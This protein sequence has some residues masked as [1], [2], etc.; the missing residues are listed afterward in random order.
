MLRFLFLVFSL[1]VWI[2]AEAAVA[3]VLTPSLSLFHFSDG[4]KREYPASA[5]EH[6]SIK[7]K[8][9]YT[10][11][12]LGVCY[13]INGFCLGLKYLQGEI[14]SKISA[15]N[16]NG[17]S[18]SV[19]HGPGLTLGYSGPEGI[20]AHVSALLGAKKD[21]EDEST[22]YFCKSA[23]ILELGY[24][25]KVSSVRIGPLL[26]LYQFEYNKR[27]INGVKSSMKPNEGDTFIMPQLALWVDL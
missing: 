13:N 6:D 7:Y 11:I 18:T 8:K 23:Y 24:G 20:V 10:F 19:F 14:E 16:A 17:K 12:N 9:T 3:Q 15:P 5:D 2:Q 21:I 25:F 27:E 22:T 4:S 1:L 26:G